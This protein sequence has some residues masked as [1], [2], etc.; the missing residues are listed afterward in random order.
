MLWLEMLRVAWDSLLANKLRSILTTLGVL[1]GVAAVITMLAIGQGA[2]EEQMRR[3]QQL[4]ANV[5][6][7]FPGRAQRGAVWAGI[8]SVQSLTLAG[9][10]SPQQK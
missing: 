7:V 2:R 6:L 9:C 10:G 5:I 1:I 4:G 8:G 3:I